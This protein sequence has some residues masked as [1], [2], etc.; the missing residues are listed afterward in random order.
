MLLTEAW[1]KGVVCFRVFNCTTKWGEKHYCGHIVVVQG[2]KVDVCWGL[3]AKSKPIGG[4]AHASEFAAWATVMKK[5]SACSTTK[6]APAPIS[7][8]EV[9]PNKDEDATPIPVFVRKWFPVL[10]R[11]G[12][13]IKFDREACDDMWQ[14]CKLPPPHPAQGAL[15]LHVRS[16]EAKAEALTDKTKQKCL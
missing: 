7:V 14:I 6:D 3:T 8:G 15:G 12:G 1:K 5:D 13:R 16:S 4:D 9:S 11:Y 2:D 10:A